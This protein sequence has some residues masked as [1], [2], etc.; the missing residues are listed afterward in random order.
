DNTCVVK[1]KIKLLARWRIGCR[2]HTAKLGQSHIHRRI[3]T[4]Q[5]IGN[6]QIGYH[7][8]YHAY[9]FQS[10]TTSGVVIDFAHVQRAAIRQRVT[11][12]DSK[13][14]AATRMTDYGNTSLLLQSRRK[15]FSATA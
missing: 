1:S 6:S 4:S 7:V 5:K 9:A 10:R 2:N 13:N 15:Y 12:I 8:R 14:A 3:T 11:P